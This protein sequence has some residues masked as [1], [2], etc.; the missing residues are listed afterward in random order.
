MFTLAPVV[1]ASRC[2]NNIK[3]V[4]KDLF[5][6]LNKPTLNVLAST[7]Q[8]SAT[9]V[10][11]FCANPTVKGSPQTGNQ[12]TSLVGARMGLDPICR[13]F[14]FLQFTGTIGF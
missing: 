6:S 7:A 11:W 4:R 14:S 8:H 3:T 9:I 2:E 12:C 1:L 5:I 10:E 13:T